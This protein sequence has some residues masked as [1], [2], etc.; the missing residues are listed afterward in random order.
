MKKASESAKRFLETHELLTLR[1]ANLRFQLKK[2][3]LTIVEQR[4]ALL[5][6]NLREAEAMKKRLMDEQE[7]AIHRHQEFLKEL[8]AKY[9]FPS[10][11]FGFDPETG[12]V[13][14]TTRLIPEEQK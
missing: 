4:E 10:E 6:L 11:G 12:E 1:E 9:E 13:K 2:K 3:D 8:N 5:K 7:E 14:E